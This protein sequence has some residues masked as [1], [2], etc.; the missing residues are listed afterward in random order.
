MFV[1]NCVLIVVCCVLLVI[2]IACCFCSCFL[3][4][5]LFWCWLLWF[6]VCCYYLT[7]DV[8]CL[9]RIVC[10]LLLFDV[11][12]LFA[13]GCL[14]LTDRTFLVYVVVVVIRCFWVNHVACCFFC[15]LF[16]ECCCSLSVVVRCV[17]FV[18]R[19]LR[20]FVYC[21]SLFL[22]CWS[23]VVGCLLLFC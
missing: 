19:C 20:Y 22:S 12:S 10:S 3:W 21:C 9:L 18:V 16:V 4:D 14:V 11:C 13:R 7:F 5:A 17:L 8:W 23:S 15:Y 6:V 1:V 2:V